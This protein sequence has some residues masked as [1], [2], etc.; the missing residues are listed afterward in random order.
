MAVTVTGTLS[1]LYKNCPKPSGW[2][3]CKFYAK[4]TTY[5]VTGE[6]SLNICQG[7]ELKM[8]LE[9]SQKKPGEFE[10]K[11]IEMLRTKSNLDLYLPAFLPYGSS[12]LPAMW[13]IANANGGDLLGLI[14]N[15]PDLFGHLFSTKEVWEE[16]ADDIVYPFLV[17]EIKNQFPLLRR[18]VIR[19]LVEAY[20]S[21]A[22]KILK[23]DPYVPLFRTERIKG[24]TWRAAES[25]AVQLG[26]SP[27][28]QRRM[29]C[30]VFE[31]L[32]EFYEESSQVCVDVNESDVYHKILDRARALLGP[33]VVL[34]EQDMDDA[35]NNPNSP[36]TYVRYKGHVYVY[37]KHMRQVESGLVSL[38][39]EMLSKSDFVSG[40]L[41]D[42]LVIFDYINEYETCAGRKLDMGQ[43]QAVVQCLTNR[44]SVLTGGPGCGKTTTVG[45]ILY[46]WHR[47]TGGSV[48][49]CAPTWMAVKRT[50]DSV[51]NS[52]V[53][54]YIMNTKCVR[55]VASCLVNPSYKDDLPDN[56]PIF[57]IGKHGLPMFSDTVHLLVV[58][59]SSMIGLADAARL[60]DMHKFCQIIW[61]GDNDQLP[62]IDP[63]NFFGDMCRSVAMPVSY[64]RINHRTE[65]KTIVANSKSI[66]NGCQYGPLVREPGVFDFI[67]F[68]PVD[69]KTTEACANFIADRYVAYLNAGYSCFDVAVLAPVKQDAYYGSTWDLNLRIQNRLN[70]IPTVPAQYVTVGS[71]ICMNTP[72]VE[73]PTL[74]SLPSNRQFMRFRVGDKV[75]CT[76][77][78]PKE[79]RTNGDVGRIISY[80]QPARNGVFSQKD[81]M[82]MDPNGYVIIQFYR[83]DNY[84]LVEVD[85]TDLVE[86]ELGYA[87]TVHKS[88]GSGYQVVLYSAQHEPSC[89]NFEFVTRNMFYTAVTR[90]ERV[91]E[92][93]G[94]M[95]A[96]NRSVVKKAKPR[97]SLLAEYLDDRFVSELDDCGELD[98]G[99]VTNAMRI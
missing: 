37:S 2:F 30:A 31:A 93:I 97:F 48:S 88:Q 28:S 55:T 76:K 83:G 6:T 29:Y 47:I 21:T 32:K 71:Y 16:I 17:D 4:G 36:M 59:E 77:N 5:T 61:V 46:C 99:A 81:R 63:G 51:Q 25:V 14:M 20:R 65:S 98:I 57:R 68:P 52:F 50:K 67:S 19:N 66:L 72:G 62:S 12:L 45:C 35:I 34:T 44:V 49:V 79:H 73:I 39:E 18:H 7:M 92:V 13:S 23:S 38:M 60:L 75:V 80:F 94:S 15:Q 96:V 64:L 53:S 90:A 1:Y 56:E 26:L 8:T 40:F 95:D 85:L 74:I 3:G 91:V 11:T 78:R 84:D 33:N 82:S 10:A 54:D 69:N 58:D 70:P 43:V 22:L 86:F 9:A 89:W 87:L 41:K 42:D 24:Y 27:T